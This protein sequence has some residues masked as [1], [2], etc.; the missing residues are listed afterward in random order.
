MIQDATYKRKLTTNAAIL[1]RQSLD[2]N[3]IV[4]YEADILYK[5]RL[6][7]SHKKMA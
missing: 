3:I 6:L 4:L 5:G 1:S 7:I 2:I